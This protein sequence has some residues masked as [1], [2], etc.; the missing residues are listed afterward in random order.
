MPLRISNERLVVLDGYLDGQGQLQFRYGTEE[1]SAHGDFIEVICD[2]DVE[3]RL[4]YSGISAE[5]EEGG[6]T[7]AW[8]QESQAARHSFSSGMTEAAEVNTNPPKL[9][10]TQVTPTGG[11]PDR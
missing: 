6:Q 10:Y 11:L 1:L 7:V 9:I 3:F 5:H 8:T 4:Q 2:Q